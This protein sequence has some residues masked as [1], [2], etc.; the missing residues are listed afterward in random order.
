MPSK[1]KTVDSTTAGLEAARQLN[2]PLEE[3]E[4][5]EEQQQVEGEGEGEGSQEEGSETEIEESEGRQEEGEGT[6][7]PKRGSFQARFNELYREKKDLE[8]VVMQL[9]GQIDKVAAQNA[10]TPKE[11]VLPDFNL[12]TNTEMATWNMGQLNKIKDEILSAVKGD[13]GAVT[14]KLGERDIATELQ[15]TAAEFKDFRNFLPE[16]IDLAERHPTLNARQV[17]FLASGNKDALKRSVVSSIKGQIDK[18]KAA[19]VERRSSTAEQSVENKKFKTVKEAGIAAAR[20][21]GM[22]S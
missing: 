12:M 11:E 22:I 13:I 3:E 2:L 18:K 21:I 8:R 5:S 4:T 1:S 9:V 7:K 10:P 14:S 6:P 20:K 15:A 17:Y 16:M 19:R